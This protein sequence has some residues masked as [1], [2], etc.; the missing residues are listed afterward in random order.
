MWMHNKIYLYK[1][2]TKAAQRDVS[3]CLEYFQKWGIPHWRGR[4]TCSFMSNEK[5]IVGTPEDGFTEDS[6]TT[7]KQ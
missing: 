6:C 5:I 4:Y 1:N 3:A 7:R 2:Q